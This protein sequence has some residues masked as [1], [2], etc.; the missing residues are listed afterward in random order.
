[1]GAGHALLLDWAIHKCFVKL[2]TCLHVW[3]NKKENKKDG[4]AGRKRV[5]S[6][7]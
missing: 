2:Y 1:M 4:W 5:G 3:C 7:T 6:A